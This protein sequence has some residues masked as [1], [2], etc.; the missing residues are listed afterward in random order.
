MGIRVFKSLEEALAA[1]FV[2]FDRIPDGYLVRKSTGT[3]FA[4]AI[5]K[6]ERDGD[7]R[8]NER[9]AAERAEKATANR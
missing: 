4:L 2:V 5:V 7:Q 3:Q 6:L 1:G 9:A 8:P